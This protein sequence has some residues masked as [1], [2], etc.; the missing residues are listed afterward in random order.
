MAHISDTVTGE[1]RG[2][3]GE[4]F[5]R[6]TILGHCSLSVWV[7]QARLLP[8]GLPEREEGEMAVEGE[9]HNKKDIKEEAEVPR[10]PQAQEPPH[11]LVSSGCP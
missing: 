7:R 1:Q 5:R 2:I 6:L 8:T 9:G 3:L 10:G 11:R 4:V